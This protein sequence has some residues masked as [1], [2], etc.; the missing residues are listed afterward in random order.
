MPVSFQ[1]DSFKEIAR[2]TYVPLKPPHRKG[3]VRGTLGS[4]VLT[5]MAQRLARGAHNSEVTR[6]KRVAGIYHHIAMVH[7]GTGATCTPLAQRQSTQAHN[8]GVTGS[9]LVGGTTNRYGVIRQHVGHPSSPNARSMLAIGIFSYYHCQVYRTRPS[10]WTLNGAS[11][12]SSEEERL[13]PDPVPLDQ[14]KQWSDRGRLSAHNGED[15]GSK[16]TAGNTHVFFIFT[17]RYP[18]TFITHSTVSYSFPVSMR[19][20]QAPTTQ[21]LKPLCADKY[22][23][24]NIPTQCLNPSAR[25]VV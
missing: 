25:W 23:N 8:L 2:G 20:R 19:G 6:S 18:N 14:R 9:K 13:N 7:Q 12:R 5:G 17:G 10:S 16:P 22:L 11:R 3:G 24:M 1:F 4:L 15:V 21:C